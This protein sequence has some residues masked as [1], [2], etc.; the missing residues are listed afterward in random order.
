MELDTVNILGRGLGMED[1]PKENCWGIN[2]IIFERPVDIHFDMHHVGRMQP[3]QIERRLH[4]I[5]RAN[6]LNI[7]VYACDAPAGTTFIRYPI[8][9]VL[10]EFPTGFFSTGVCYM[11]AL[12]LLWKV[13]ELHFYGVNHSRTDLLGEYTM[14]KPGV[15]YWL[16]VC[17]GRG[18][19]YTVHGNLAEIGSTFTRETYGYFVPQVEMVR[20]YSS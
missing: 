11:I 8:E 6:K 7:P 1:A 9:E 18:V 12:A 10:K 19:K 15:D 20:K 3:H 14:Q 17:L 4:T 2:S 5:K 13:K 16:G